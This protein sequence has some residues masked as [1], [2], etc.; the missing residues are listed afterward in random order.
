MM[1][2]TSC[3]P[4]VSNDSSASYYHS[5]SGTAGADAS[6]GE[7]IPDIAPS[8]RGRVKMGQ[9]TNESSPPSVA[10]NSHPQNSS[11]SL[12]LND[13][14][15]PGHKSLPNLVW[16]EWRTDKN[17]PGL[18]FRYQREGSTSDRKWSNLKNE[19]YGISLQTAGYRWGI[20][21]ENNTS[22]TFIIWKLLKVYSYA[23]VYPTEEVGPVIEQWYPIIRSGPGV[24][25][26]S[27]ADIRYDL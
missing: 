21:I 25:Y 17:L 9:Q 27:F 26:L 12:K 7:E 18:R 24:N 1:W 14:P 3:A 20:E 10:S 6:S 4:P 5:T 11:N 19:D 16:T 2:V 23:Q 15:P 8:S 22:Q 13:T